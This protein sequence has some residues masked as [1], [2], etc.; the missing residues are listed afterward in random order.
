MRYKMQSSSNYH[1]DGCMIVLVRQ[2]YQ[3]ILPQWR[4]CDG[5]I[6][7]TVLSGDITTVTGVWWYY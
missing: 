6:S 1:S 7:E 4:V 3:E 5:I 2:Y